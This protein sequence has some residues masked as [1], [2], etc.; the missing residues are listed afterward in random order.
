MKLVGFGN[1]LRHAFR[2][3]HR[4][5][6]FSGI[7]VVI[8]GLGLA[9]VVSLYS[10]FDAL[11][12]RSLPIPEPETLVRVVRMRP[13]MSPLVDFRY[14]V[15]LALQKA[16]SLNNVCAIY[17]WSDSYRDGE[18]P[19]RVRV[20]AISDS[21]FTLFRVDAQL[22]RIPFPDDEASLGTPPVVVSHVFWKR[23]YSLD[24][25]VLNRKVLVHG[26][27]FVVLGVFPEGFN[28]VTIDT[29]PDVWV[30]LS[31]LTLLLSNENAAVKLD[32]LWYEII[33]RRK[34][35][36]DLAAARDETYS[37]FRGAMERI[38]GQ[39]PEATRQISENELGGKFELEPIGRGVSQL[40]SQVS[41]YV[42]FSLVGAGVLLIM[43]CT[44][45]SALSAARWISR[46][47]ELA[48]RLALGSSVGQLCRLAVLEALFLVALGALAGFVFA[49]GIIPLLL[50]MLPPVQLLDASVVPLSLDARFDFRVF[51]FAFAVTCGVAVLVSL[52]P[53]VQALR[54]DIHSPLRTARSSYAVKGDVILITS[55][56]AFCTLLLVCATLL[57]VTLRRLQLTDPGFAQDHVLTF[58]LD[59]ETAGRVEAQRSLMGQ[60]LLNEM[61]Q[62]PG[63]RGVAFASRP[64]MRGTG[65]RMTVAPTGETTR[66]D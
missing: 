21:C 48:V 34:S 6:I 15:Y 36:V 33:A 60:R 32:D 23:H 44:N 47:S 18:M 37:L 5:A 59:L 29:S 2:S 3:I 10:I 56:I 66:P 51:A 12:L 52:L 7:T 43:V 25:D 16:K 20:E 8:L 38:I 35:G 58:A 41:S 26:H 53:A 39:H 27:P 63:V 42:T 31:A 17:D 28:G 61:K 1:D 9:A 46:E 13:E 22:G 54:T 40:R 4:H 49:L 64:L 11:L 24:H 65:F 55:Q 19:E 45:V 57:T 50:R 14:S 30:P 62:L